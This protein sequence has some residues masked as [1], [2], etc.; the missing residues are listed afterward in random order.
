MSK[1]YPDEML[2]SICDI[3]KEMLQTYGIKGLIID[4]D[5]TLTH[6][7]SQEISSEILSWV[8]QMKA[9]YPI[10]LLSNNNH[11]RVEPFAKML[12]LPFIPDGAKPIPS[13]GFTKAAKQIGTKPN[14]T[15]VIGDQIFTDIFGGNLFGGVTFRVTP[16][17]NEGGVFFSIKRWLENLIIKNYYKKKGNK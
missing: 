9:S 4:I 11:E 7:D 15:A 10:I 3:T 5:N 14:E 2:E 16:M 17:H 13:K 1:F 12:G 6:H 8:N